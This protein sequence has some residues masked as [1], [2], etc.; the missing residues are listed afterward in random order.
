MGAAT[1]SA[2]FSATVS[3]AARVTPWG[4][5]AAVS[6]PTMRPTASRASSRVPSVRRRRTCSLSS[7]RS[8]AARDCQ[9]QRISS[10]KARAGWMRRHSRSRPRERARVPRGSAAARTLPAVRSPLGVLGK[11][12]RRRRSREVMHRPMATT[13]WG[14]Q[15]GSPSSRSRT[16]PP[17]AAKTISMESVLCIPYFPGEVQ[18]AACPPGS[19]VQQKAAAAGGPPVKIP[20]SGQGEALQRRHLDAAVGHNYKALCAGGQRPVHQMGKGAAHPPGQRPAQPPST[21]AR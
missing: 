20:P 3:T 16:K 12:A 18:Q 2:K 15:A 4:L 19:G 9:H 17:R 6:R 14:I 5:R 8:R 10:A 7:A 1:P 13:G 21:Q 11:A